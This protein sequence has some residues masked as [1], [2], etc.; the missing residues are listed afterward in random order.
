MFRE[1]Y[2]L[3]KVH[4]TSAHIRWKDGRVTYSH[5]GSIRELF[6]GSFNEKELVEKFTEIGR[7]N[8]VVYGEAYG[9]NLQ[10]MYET[11]GDEVRFIVFDVKIDD[12]WLNVPQMEKIANQL[13]LES[14]SYNRIPTTIEAIDEQRDLPSVV[15][16]ARG[17]PNKRREGVVL[18]PIVELR[19]NS[20]KRI[21]AKHKHPDFCETKTPRIVNASELKVLSDANEIAEEWVTPMRLTHVLDKVRQEVNEPLSMKNT[22]F[23]LHSMIEDIEREGKGEIVMGKATR[24]AI[25]KATVP[26]YKAKLQEDNNE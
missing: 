18:R 22:A 12:M 4:G 7:D 19:F 2:A 1:C 9:G 20:G 26:L 8:V 24:G 3:E 11:Y 15:G 6:V 17:F 13:N 23:V 10:R 16:E 25:C 5:G 14:V 21:I